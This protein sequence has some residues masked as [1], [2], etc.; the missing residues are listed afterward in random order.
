MPLR[1]NKPV[2]FSKEDLTIIRT[3]IQIHNKHISL[4]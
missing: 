1:S 3:L 2:R 4:Y